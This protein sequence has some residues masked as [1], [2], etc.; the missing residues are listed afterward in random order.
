MTIDK[1]R[2]SMFL[3]LL[4]EAAFFGVLIMSYLYYYPSYV[5]ER[6]SPLA[7]DPLLSGIFT[8]AL[9]ASSFTLWRAQKSTEQGQLGGQRVWLLATVALGAIFLG[10]Q[11]WEYT[12]LIAEN[13]TISSSLF[14]TAFF[15][16]T[17]I[18]GLHVLGGLLTLTIL[19]GLALRGLLT[20]HRAIGLTMVELYWHF[21]DVVWIVIFATVYVWPNL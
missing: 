5:G 20:P 7:L 14:G 3:F 12:Q 9:L 8:V 19:L 17:G 13:I 4:S 15:T 11:A 18:H 21:V 10:G 16:L 6:N 2:L 1:N